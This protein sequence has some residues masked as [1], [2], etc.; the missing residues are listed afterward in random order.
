MAVAGGVIG[1]LLFLYIGLILSVHAC[2]DPLVT[3][4]ALRK[5]I[6]PCCS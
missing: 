1:I 4:S 3:S 5:E 2:P 6:Q